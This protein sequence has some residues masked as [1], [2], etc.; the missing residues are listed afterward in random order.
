LRIDP[1]FR[2]AIKRLPLSSK[3]RLRVAWALVENKIVA[4][5]IVVRQ[6]DFFSFASQFP[7][8]VL[9]PV[10]FFALLRV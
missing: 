8:L 7:V 5:P 6:I 10:N 1:E 9:D 2:F 4:R 3:A